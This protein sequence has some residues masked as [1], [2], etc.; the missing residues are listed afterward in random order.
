MLLAASI[1]LLAAGL[2]C[3]KQHLFK[4][5][6]TTDEECFKHRFLGLKC[7]QRALITNPIIVLRKWA[8]GLESDFYR[9]NYMFAPCRIFSAV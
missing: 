1:L 5:F 4:K 2:Q 7:S 3:L 8:V 9:R 6:G